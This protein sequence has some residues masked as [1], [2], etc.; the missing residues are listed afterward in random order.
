MVDKYKSLLEEGYK[1]Y[2]VEKPMLSVLFGKDLNELDEQYRDVY[3][4]KID[5]LEFTEVHHEY[6]KDLFHNKPELVNAQ[7]WLKEGLSFE[8][9]AVKTLDDSSMYDFILIDAK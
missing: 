8:E 7:G 4:D 3:V 2:L 9:I 6:V 5:E 1:F